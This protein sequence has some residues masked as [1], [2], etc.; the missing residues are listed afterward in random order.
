M[1]SAFVA[2]VLL[3]VGG[4]LGLHLI[5]L[6]RNAQ[7]LVWAS[8]LGFFGV[9][10]FRDLFCIP[11]YA[12]ECRLDASEV[13]SKAAEIVEWPSRPRD[14]SIAKGVA[15]CLYGAYLGGIL[16]MCST[17]KF[18]AS[19]ELSVDE[20]S[21]ALEVIGVSLGVW[22]V[23]T[24]GKDVV[25]YWMCFL[26][27]I[28]GILLRDFMFSIEGTYVGPGGVVFSS[29]VT[30]VLANWNTRQW[31]ATWLEAKH[32][33]VWK[34]LRE[35]KR[36]SSCGMCFGMTKV[37]LAFMVF[38]VISLV[39]LY[40]HGEY[41]VRDDVTG[42]RYVVPLKFLVDQY[43]EEHAENFEEAFEGLERIREFIEREGFI[44]FLRRLREQS[45][46]YAREEAFKVLDLPPDANTAQ[47]RKRFRELSKKYHPDMWVSASREIQEMKA[48]EY[49]RIVQAF[50]VLKGV[51]H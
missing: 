50:E 41:P 2:Y 26:G 34:K 18:A 24:N 48:Q 30:V 27:C 15:M 32:P 14:F 33:L 13:R 29:L 4:P 23:G 46:K 10:L 16:R 38:S 49:E 7:A 45:P 19:F 36:N 6:G 22:L 17:R 1:V 39:G 8:S 37:Y 31:N 3:L 43:F 11:R 12:R 47:I 21:D 51:V 42:D 25:R 35:E 20:M 5:Y 9:G 28:M 44:E 40:Q